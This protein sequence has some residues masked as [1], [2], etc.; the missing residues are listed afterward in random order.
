MNSDEGRGL[1]DFNGFARVLKDD[2]RVREDAFFIK[3]MKPAE[4]FE[5]HT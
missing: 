1:I 4:V 5:C 2:D 3:K